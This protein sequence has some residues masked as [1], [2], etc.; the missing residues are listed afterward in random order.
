MSAYCS[1]V[2]RPQID[3][4]HPIELRVVERRRA[5]ADALEREALDQLVAGHDR[6]L[7]VRRPAEQGEEVHQ[8]GSDVALPAEL[9]HGHRAVPLGELLAVLAEHV[10]HV[11]VDRRL[12]A[13]CAQDDELL[14]RVRDVVVAADHVGD[15]VEPV[16]D[17][18]GEVVGRAA[19][20]AHEHEVLELVRR[21][22]D[23]PLDSVLP[24]D[25]AL[26][27]HADPDRALILVR[28]PLGDEAP[29]LLAGALGRI[30]L[31][32]RVPVPLD[33]EPARASARS[34]PP[35]PPPHGW[36]RCSRSAAGT[37][38]RARAQTAS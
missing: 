21:E 8:S 6:R 30:E 9:V 11:R 5:A 19:V 18:V 12:G 7:P 13:E 27:G 4:V 37:R 22:L 28:R 32:A 17:G 29:G 26:V 31:E 34:A 23:R 14:R 36:C 35:P 3:A 38:R 16:V 15:P 25:R 33:P 10:R 24:A 1:G 20:R 2:E